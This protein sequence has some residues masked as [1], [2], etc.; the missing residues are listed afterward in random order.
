MTFDAPTDFMWSTRKLTWNGST[1]LEPEAE[2]LWALLPDRLKDIARAEMSAGNMPYSMQIDR[3]TYVLLMSFPE[4][5]LRPIGNCGDVVVHTKYAAGNYCYD[6]M[7]CT[8]ELGEPA[9][10]LTFED[11]TYDYDSEWHPYTNN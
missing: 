3:S 9:S 11:P 6:G 4:G 2:F 5:P 10:F 8:Y 7:F 1:F